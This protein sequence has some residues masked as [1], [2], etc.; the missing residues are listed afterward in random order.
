MYMMFT[1]SVEP[2]NE[3]VLSTLKRRFWFDLIKTDLTGVISLCK[4]KMAYRIKSSNYVFQVLLR[5][6]FRSFF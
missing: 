4:S 6:P 1:S 2:Y 5:P 3:V